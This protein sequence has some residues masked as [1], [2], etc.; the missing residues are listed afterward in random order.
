IAMPATLADADIMLTSLGHQ[1]A[2]ETLKATG[3]AACL[4]KPV[5]QSLLFDCIATTL[6]GGSAGVIRPTKPHFVERSSVDRPPRNVRILV[7]EDNTI[8]QQVA[9]GQLEKL[10][11]TADTVANGLESLEALQ[12]IPYDIVLMDCMM[13][14]MD[15]YEATAQIRLRERQR[16]AGFESRRP[17]HVIAM[18]ANAMQGDREKCLAAGMND[19]VSKP[20][21]TADLRRALEQWQLESVGIPKAAGAATAT[22]GTP[23]AQVS[24]VLDPPP[25]PRNGAE[26]P[27]DLERLIEVTLENPDKLRRLVKTY[28]KS[29]DEMILSLEQ[30]IQRGAIKEIRRLAHKWGGSSS[31]CGM[32]A[33]VP[34][35][36]QLER[37]GE[38]DYLIRAI[39]LHAET[40]KQLA[41]VRQFLN[42]Y[43][44]STELLTNAATV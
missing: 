1:L 23:P 2:G 20:V 24:E 13:P 3:I 39:E 30:A 5:K 34:L 33:V 37:M 18:T 41:R 31:T 10:G 17:V 6:A 4:I 25:E 9:L 29:S 16:A 7:A 21:R 36:G 19:Y 44:Q 8:N 32:I 28:L 15:G 11:Y 14:E 38:A 26:T 40:S 43:L 35:L 22:D 27:V 12:R 42:E